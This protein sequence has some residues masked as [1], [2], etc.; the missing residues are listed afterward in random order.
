M[1]VFPMPPDNLLN[2][3]RSACSAALLIASLLFFSGLIQL[4]QARELHAQD[5]SRQIYQILAENSRE[6]VRTLPENERE[7]MMAM[8]SMQAGRLNEA[9]N[10]L[11]DRSL[12]GDP[13]VALIRA[14]VY[15]R[16]AV[17]A[18]GQAGDYVPALKRN[19][20]QMKEASFGAGLVEAEQRLRAFTEKLGG[21]FQGT[22]F[23]L[24]VVG[25]TVTNVFMIDRARSRMFIFRND[26][27]GGLQQVSD[28]YVVTGAKTGEKRRRGDA[29][30]PS[31]IYRFV[32][33]LTGRRLPAGYGPVAFPIDYPNAMDRL[34]HYN[35]SGIWMHGYADGVN[36]RLPQN[37]KGC[38]VLPNPR[39]LSIKERVKLGYSWVVIGEHITFGDEQRKQLLLKSIRL[40]IKA[41]KRDW[42]S[43]HTRAYLSHYH[44]DFRSGKR[45]LRSWS[46]YKY[47]VNRRK[48]FI[49]LDLSDFTIVHHPGRV[50]EGEAVLVEFDQRY[51]SDN[52]S[53]S[54]RKR[55]YLVRKSNHAAW[56]ILVEEEVKALPKLASPGFLY[57][58]DRSR[59]KPSPVQ[60][61]RRRAASM[62][63]LINLASFT[64]KSEALK[65]MSGV[66][67][68]GKG[69]L[70]ISTAIVQ[71]K[72]W[73]RVRVGYFDNRSEADRALKR[74][75]KR[76]FLP[77]A[78]IDQAR[79]ETV[80]LR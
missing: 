58:A 36:R 24:L 62:R 48:R 8:L 31:G 18:A 14:E 68:S 6:E 70:L 10:A 51:R 56:K 61:S 50:R 76:Y 74:I 23:D 42:E 13:L 25:S 34:H 64:S 39:L 40:A 27:H 53:G 1:K 79:M 35:G 29:R 80:A 67:L 71:K 7:I 43:L 5:N 37:S 78:W 38:F 41:W 30:T 46:R 11:Q 44:P 57:E 45:N 33:K 17:R 20:A 3:S 19:V 55:L 15:R 52:F 16:Q 12:D 47:R 22:P 28:E 26:G 2:I 75:S 32:D 66:S 54:N 4:A 21:H 59:E 60:S 73:Y 77:K 72:R 9:M 63:W 69:H 65:Y 49:H